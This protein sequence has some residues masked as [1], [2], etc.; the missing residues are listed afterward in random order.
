[1][2]LSLKMRNRHTKL[3]RKIANQLAVNFINKQFGELFGNGPMMRRGGSW[4]QR[5]C[6][7]FFWF[8]R[9]LLRP[10]PNC[11]CT[12]ASSGTYAVNKICAH[13]VRCACLTSLSMEWKCHIH[14]GQPTTNKWATA[15]FLF[16]LTPSFRQATYC[17]LFSDYLSRKHC[18]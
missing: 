4:A 1:V 2:S 5:L 17:L 8:S 15:I 13:M 3:Q 12:T 14:T 10:A 6:R 7:P 18:Y 11:C 9:A 16:R